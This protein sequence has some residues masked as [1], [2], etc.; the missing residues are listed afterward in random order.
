MN[1]SA[2]P[3]DAL[4]RTRFE[5]GR[6]QTNSD[7]IVPIAVCLAI[8]LFVR[9]LYRRD[10]VELPPVLGWLLTA[11][12]IAV[13]Y[14]LLGLYLEPQWRVEREMPRN[15]RAA[16]VVDGSLSMRQTD[17]GG[18]AAPGAAAAPVASRSGQAVDALAKS[19]LLADLRKVHDVTVWRFDQEIQRIASFEKST[20]A[21]A[22]PRPEVVWEKLLAPTGVETRLGQALSQVLSEEQN[23]PLAGVIV[24]TDGGQ[25][26]GPG[27]EA[28]VR[29]AQAAR[30]PLLAVGLGSDRQPSNVRVSDLSAPPRAFPGDKYTVTGYLQSQRMAGRSVT[31]QLLSRETGGA[32][33]G[34]VE[35]ARQVTLGADGEATPVVFEVTPDRV[36][37]RTL[38]LRVQAPPDDQNRDDNQRETDVEIVD[39][40]TRVLLLAGGPSREYQFLRSLLHRD[41]STTL[42]V[43]LQ[44]ARPGVS[45]DAAR[46]LGAFPT[47][48]E[49]LYQYDCLIALD[50]DW[51]AIGGKGLDLLE[52]WVA[53]QG[54]G[55]IVA[56]GPVEAGKSLGAWTQD[57]QTAK[58]RALFPVTFYDNLSVGA[59]APEG[60]DA[61]P[62][63]FTREGL[64]AQF[65]WLDDSA[66]ESA[67]AWAA[68]AGPHYCFS[69]RGPKPGA[70][71][72]AR[73][74]DPRLSQSGRGMPFFVG[75]FY[76]SGRVFYLGSAEMWRL[77]RTD[78]GGFEKFYTK[79]V[80]HVAQGRLLRGS[81]RGA[82]L[83]GQDHGYLV[84]GSVEVRAQ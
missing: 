14:G 72:Y 46:V 48:K 18:A 74:S 6:I 29:A 57:A 5:W 51:Q 12:R 11:L 27:P 66:A 78:E 15:S 26:A 65:L 31:V 9:Y 75:Q 20:A 38:T 13:F 70:T 7:W 64:E 62:L 84:G 8:M 76:G 77:R 17:A 43:L 50:P 82:L 21:D 25:N 34:L 81:A 53:E 79:L 22:A 10:A 3:A 56:P 80:R 42:E 60:K 47:T 39:H 33:Q 49:E 35:T 69:V 37:K 4:T 52:S 2:L 30:V 63:E 16:I 28:A 36:G 55:L 41:R 83:V 58:L 68:F 54:A 59:A 23:A 45:Q 67:R 61:W 1:P 71:V 24:L 73:F 32:E 40:K 44:S 19:P